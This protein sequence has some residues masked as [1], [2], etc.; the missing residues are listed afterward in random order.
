MSRKAEKLLERMRQTK[1]GWKPNDLY[2]LYEG[3]GFIIKSGG[4]HD[5]VTHPDY[6]QLVTSLPRHKKLA[7]YVVGEAIKMV[8]R[9]KQLEQEQERSEDD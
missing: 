9:L 6:P 2:S 1:A 3:F 5:L 7:K 8:D 4:S